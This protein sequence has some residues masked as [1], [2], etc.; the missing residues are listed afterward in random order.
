MRNNIEQLGDC[1][2]HC[3]VY[4]VSAKGNERQD[5]LSEIEM[6]K[7]VAE[8]Q[9]PHVVGLLGCVTIQEPLCLITEFVKYGDLLSYLRTNRRMVI[10]INLLSSIMHKETKNYCRMQETARRVMLEMQPIQSL[11][12]SHLQISC[13][14]PTRLP[15]E[16][17]NSFHAKLLST[18]NYYF[19]RSTLL[20]LELSIEILLAETS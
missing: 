5:F 9:N 15:L 7:K 2:K 3:F 8:G 17:Y 14:L 11:E 18:D 19:C 13:P 20:A 6:M 4:I 16:W 10:I 12:M 1:C